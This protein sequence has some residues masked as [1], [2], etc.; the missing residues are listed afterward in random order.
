VNLTI[1]TG[2]ASGL[3]GVLLLAQGPLVAQGL[4]F[5]LPVRT[6]ASAYGDAVPTPEQVIGHRIGT[7]HTR[8]DQLVEFFRAVAG[9][10]DRVTLHVHGR[11]HGGRP[12][13]HA[14]VT[15]PANHARLEQIR[16]ANLRL[17]EAPG[18]VSDAEVA[19]MPAVVYMGYSVHGNEAS[20]SEA[21]VLTLYHLA[22]GEGPAVQQVLDNT[23]VI[24]D[25]SL[26]P[27]GRARFADW[28]N[29]NRGRV[30]TA[31]PQDR[32]HN[33]PWP[34]GRTNHYF[35]DLNR[36]WLPAQ[37]PESQG[38]LELYYR[39]R[40]QLHLDFHEMGGDATYFFQ[41]GVPS[42][43]NANTHPRVHE[44][45][46]EVARYHA[47]ALDGIGALYYTRE[48]FDDFY[49][50]K[51]STYPDV[52][53][54][55][56]ILFEQA[57]S[58][59][60]RSE[61]AWGELTYPFTIR[62]QFLTSLSSLEAAAGIRERLLR[63]QRD[64]Y[65]E[66]PEVARRSPVK[67]WVIGLE[68]DRT[69]AQALA[70]MLLRHRIRL[71]ELAREFRQDGQAFRPGSAFVVPVD[72]PQA[73]LVLGAMERRF[74]FDDSLFYD[75]STWTTPLAFGVPHVEVR[76]SPVA[77][78]G[79]PITEMPFDGGGVVGGR[80]PY[81]YVMEWGRTFAPRALYRL[82]EAG[83][84]PALLVEPFEST[85]AGQPRRFQRGAIVVPV[86]Q[87]DAASPLA[88]DRVHALVDSLAREEHVVFHAV[89]TGLNPV[90]VD[91][92]SRGARVLEMPRIA[93]LSGTGT[94]SSEVGE[95]WHLLDHRLGIP[96]SLLDVGAVARADLGRYNTLVM[97]GY[98]SGLTGAAAER[99]RDW[100][101]A[102]GTLIATTSSVP[103]VLQQE[104]LD[105]RLRETASDTVAVAYGDTE[106]W[107]G[108]QQ[109]GGSIFEVELDTT[110]PLAFGY[111]RQLPV[112]RDNQ[113]FLQPSRQP[114]ANVA[115]YARE[116]LLSGHV[117]TRNLQLARGS[118]SI[119]ARRAGGGR[120]I[121]FTDNPNFRAFWYGT[122]GLF[123][124]AVFF[125]RSF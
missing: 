28:V 125:G 79:R 83:I 43:N 113:V 8:P 103:W 96:V 112:F 48:S 5:D 47:R 68:G 78:L 122:N 20:G 76:A 45:T 89:A 80:A 9:A 100:V 54:A 88:A 21:G 13:V 95:T 86:E 70:Q 124:N 60:L 31:D 23:V 121:L 35:F 12:L 17:S 44:L 51:G 15:S 42:R 14:V 39:W 110:H 19:G 3:L 123:L 49:Y 119:V 114:G 4:P 92:G 6:G 56:G 97:A 90:G 85:G 58:R 18:E 64:M 87:R 72:Q 66:A 32:E 62:N 2:A 99:V 101:R 109:I 75:V 27:D 65:R 108:V 11:S 69:R 111:G 77:L 29:H 107:R 81:A 37:H 30:A 46:M 120:V 74:E 26:N 24:I 10:S 118:A 38:R 115:V 117:S 36:D 33:E 71:H 73:R 25:P 53:G 55:I 67:A 59:A 40:P 52:T 94:R 63:H 93:L 116:P 57:S 34:G 22:A 91:L 16:Q 82:Q 84:R 98:V 104:L 50:G 106:A 102:G 7:R 1:R 105:E 41:P 61:T